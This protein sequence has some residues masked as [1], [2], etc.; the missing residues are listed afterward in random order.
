MPPVRNARECSVCHTIVRN[1]DRIVRRTTFVG[2]VVTGQLREDLCPNCAVKA[3]TGH[4][5]ELKPV[6]LQHGKTLILP[7]AETADSDA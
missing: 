1:E 3:V 5:H 2:A 7:S 6:R 4:E